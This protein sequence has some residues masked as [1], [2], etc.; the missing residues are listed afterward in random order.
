MESLID[1]GRLQEL[2]QVAQAEFP[3][4]DPYFIYVFATDHLLRE[5]GIEPDKDV[6]EEMIE[7]SKQNE[8]SVE[9]IEN[10]ILASGDASAAPAEDAGASLHAVDE[11]DVEN[12]I[13]DEDVDDADDGSDDNE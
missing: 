9:V 11:V 6:V 10:D 5:Q 3:E 13:K 12:V 8:F 7:K 2:C 1:E 4:I